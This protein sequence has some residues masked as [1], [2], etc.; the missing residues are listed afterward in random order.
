MFYPLHKLLSGS[1]HLLR[2]PSKKEE[3]WQFS[4]LA[5][6]MDKEY[7]NIIKSDENK[8]YDEE[9]DFL[10]LQDGQLIKENLPSTVHINKHT[11]SCELEYNPFAKLASCLAPYPLE[12][13]I[14][15]DAELH[16]YLDYSQNNFINSHLNIILQEG[17]KA[18]IYIVFEG[19]EESFISHNSHIKLEKNAELVLT[20]V[21]R[22][23]TKAVL[24]SQDCLHLHE[25]ASVQKFCL[26]F[27]GEYLHH[28]VNADLHH[29]SEL[30]IG[31]LLLSQE[32]QNFIFSC[33]I[34]HLADR[35][36]SHLLSKQVLKDKSSCVF[37]ANTKIDNNT[38]LCEATQGSHAL[39]LSEQAQIHA[40]PHLEIYSDDLSASHGSTVGA[41]D[42]DASAYLISRGISPAKAK[43]ILVT[44]FVQ[45]TLDKLALTSHKQKVLE[46]LG[47]AYE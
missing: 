31:A 16:L 9:K 10:L 45:E 17:V 32:E 47:E 42:E 8:T 28:F 41:L 11:L 12:L 5:R 21:Q 13:N 7:Q 39:L 4:K 6:Y 26:L 38:K 27:S 14:F 2:L 29:K 1:T 3:K 22:L 33:D 15:E 30:D 35:S 23:S 43:S 20:Q 19:G 46:V 24:I 37:D 18:K 34:N 40:K 25:G 36:K 44:A